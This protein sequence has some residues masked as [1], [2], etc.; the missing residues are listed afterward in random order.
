[1]KKLLLLGIL[2]GGLCLASQ[3]QNKIYDFPFN[4]SFSSTVGTGAFDTTGA[5]FVY[6]RD[7]NENGA[8]SLNGNRLSAT[9]NDLP[10]GDDSRAISF[11]FNRQG[12]GNTGLFRY[13]SFSMLGIFGIYLDGSS[14][15]IFQGYGAGNDQSLD[16]TTTQNAWNHIVLMYDG[17]RVKVYYNGNLTNS[18]D[19]DRNTGIGQFSLGDVSG[20]FD[21]LKIYDDALTSTQVLNLYNHNEIEVNTTG[22]Y[23]TVNNEQIK[24]YPN[25]AQKQLNVVST[26]AIQVTLINVLGAKLNQFILN[27]GNNELDLTALQPGVYYLVSEHGKT[28]KFIKE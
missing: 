18:F 27:E 8:L 9:L 3:A 1:M 13:G 17:E 12:S 11:W 23:K 24:L 21:D 2:S 22:L 16:L 4:E 14:K 10:L 7:S 20:Y 5:S 26:T 6:D 25:P 15:L 19:R 28:V